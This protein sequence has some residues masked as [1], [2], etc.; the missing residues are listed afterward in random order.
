MSIKIC[1]KEVAETGFYNENISININT[2]CTFFDSYQDIGLAI[3]ETFGELY[4]TNNK[5]SGDIPILTHGEICYDDVLLAI[6]YCTM[7]EAI[8]RFKDVEAL[9]SIKEEFISIE[10]YLRRNNKDVFSVYIL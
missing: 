1:L 2:H 7:E 3:F 5:N 6:D 8:E 10:S 4:T 9:Q